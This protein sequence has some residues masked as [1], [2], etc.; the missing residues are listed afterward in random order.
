MGCDCNKDKISLR[1]KIRQET[2]EKIADI[3]KMW[4]ES[5]KGTST[6]TT[7]KNELGFK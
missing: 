1:K 3:K 6:I 5:S 7:N 2:K 4:Q